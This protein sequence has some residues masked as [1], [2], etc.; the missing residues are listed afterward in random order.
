MG[1][2]DAMVRVKAGCKAQRRVVLQVALVL[3]LSLAMF[4]CSR[5]MD[6][7]N[8]TPAAKQWE[9]LQSD[10][11]VVGTTPG[12]T[13]FIASVQ[14]VGQSIADVDAVTFT[15]AP[16]PNTVSK[17]VSVTWGRSA[18][19][20][21]GYLQGGSITLPVFG[22]YD[23]YENQIAY[24]IRFADGSVQQLESTIATATYTDPTSVYS[25]PTIV[26]AMAPGTSLGFSF[27]ILKS[28]IG[29]PVIVDTDGRVRWVVPVA[30]SMSAYYS[31]GQ[32]LRG[33]NN[34]PTFKIIRFDGNEI[35]LPT[36]LPQPLMQ[37][38]THNIDPGSAPGTVLAE[39]YGTDD[40]GPG[41]DDIVA[42]ISPLS[43]EPVLKTFDMA[44]I[45]TSYMRE[46]GDD[47]SA[48]VRPGIDWFHVNAS[49]YDPSDD[50]VII[51]SRENFLIKIDCR[52][53]D[54][55]W[56]FGDPTKY[57]YTF[58][59]LRAKALTLDPGGDYPIGQHA[60]SITSDGH[61]MIFNDGLESKNQ[62]AGE[63]AGMSRTFSE[64]NA[65]AVNATSMT[66]HQVWSFDYRRTI[67][68]AL[69][70]SIYEA[71]GKTYLIDYATAD[72]NKHARL[73]G[74]D[75]SHNVAFDFQYVSPGP[76]PC[77]AAWNA[78]PI[79]LDRMEIH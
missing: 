28:Q 8:S 2:A 53:K 75:A 70:G 10:V 20:S 1:I 21:D 49:V 51:S 36:V 54:V 5:G 47:P 26:K 16:R 38:F 58:P 17:P 15:I 32:F 73:V 48:F 40:L 9:A 37:Q 27:F 24:Q 23:G 39:F 6:P 30:G 43:N 18:L 11:A 56:I 71:P 35:S 45:L 77:N 65:Y 50:S 59:S 3:T 13:P 69:C 78:I 12:V 34:P 14:F 4:G 41:I 79:D 62:P 7:G 63:P 46:N 61:I 60:V 31:N 64:V 57:W 76:G 66:A 19:S 33:I 67:F 52:T 44:E 22:L 25:N 68:S 55:V 74:L 72:S 42:E 29:A